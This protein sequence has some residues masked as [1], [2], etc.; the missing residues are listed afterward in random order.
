MHQLSNRRLPGVAA[1]QWMAPCPRMVHHKVTC[2]V[3]RDVL[4]L[5][6]LLMPAQVVTSKMT[7][8]TVSVIM[9]AMAT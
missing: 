2:I 3:G 5:A 9:S 7:K 8:G 4:D 1:V 6:R